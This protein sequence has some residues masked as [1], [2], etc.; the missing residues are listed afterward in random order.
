MG[1]WSGAGV[2]REGKAQA[3]MGVD[4]A[5]LDGDGLLDLFVTNFAQDYA[6]FYRNNGKLF[7]SD[8]TAAMDLKNLVYQQ[9]KW[10]C[11]FFDFDQDAD[12]DLLVLNGHI[13]PQVDGVPALAESYRQAPVLAEND[14]G[15]LRDV[16]ARA[17]PGMGWK[18]SARGL[19]VGDIDNDGDLDLLVSA[20]DAVPLLLRNDTRPAGPWLKLRLVN[21]HGGPAIGARAIVTT[22]GKRQVGEVRSGSTYCSQSSFDLHFGLGSARR[23]E[24]VEVR[25]PDGKRTSLQDVEINRTLSVR[26]EA[27]AP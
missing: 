9:V 7:F 6:T 5:D 27:A 25:W 1:G 2:S 4:A 8:D 17:G 21:R 22:G 19:A 26:Q 11:A 18:E 13:Y 3:G 24:G 14:N 20:I 23:V 12:Q 10:G 16:T 15:K